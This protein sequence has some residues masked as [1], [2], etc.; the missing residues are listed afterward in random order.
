MNQI[1][2][3]IVHVSFEEHKDALLWNA[4]QLSSAQRRYLPIK[5][6]LDIVLSLVALVVLS[7]IFPLIAI[8][9]K[10][11]SPGPVLFKQERAGKD[12]IPFTIYKFRSMCFDAERKLLQM[13]A[14]KMH[15]VVDIKQRLKND[16]RITRVGRFLRKTTIDE[17]PQF[18]NVL[19]GHMSLVGP[20][21]LAMRE[22]EAMNWY[23]QLRISVKP[24]L[25]CFWQVGG[26]SNLDEKKRV[27]LDLR[28]IRELGLFTDFYLLLKT[29]PVLLSRNGAM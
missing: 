19:C 6:L 16:P 27:E 3:S 20:R 4:V 14:Y 1:A 23:Q 12:G 29:V 5:R 25:T 10:I 22:H 7:P 26:R 21:P 17:L 8:L 24:G 11:D 2:G 28:Y 15:S 9:I 18:I 13:D